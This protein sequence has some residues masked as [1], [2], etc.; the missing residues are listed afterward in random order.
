MVAIASP[1]PASGAYVPAPDAY[2]EAFAARG[3]PRPHYAGVLDALA[4]VDLDALTTA[5]EVDLGRRGVRFGGSGGVAAFHVDPV[6]RVLEAGEWRAL[7]TGL[8]QRTRALNAFVTDVYGPREIV[9]AGV[10]PT[11]V[12]DTAAHLEPLAAELP[13]SPVPPVLVAGLDVV[14]D[15]A[16]AFLVLEDNT[17]TPSGLAFA[18]AARAVVT[19][20]LAPP[21]LDEAASPK[22]AIEGLAHALRAAAPDGEE[23]APVLLSEGPADP[24][25]FEHRTLAEALGVP[26]V[27]LADL[28][29][30][31]DRV[32]TRADAGQHRRRVNVVYRR[33]GESR[34]TRPDGRLT[35]LAAVLL[36]PLRAGRVTCVNAFGAG[37]ADDKLVHGYVED[38]VRFYLDE[39]PVLASVR[40]HGL[41]D[42]GGRA[43]ALDR[44]GELVIKPRGGYGGHGVVVCAHAS[45]GDRRRAAA[46]VRNS[47]AQWVAQ[48]TVVLSCH[49]TVVDG[50][51]V[52]RHVDLRPFTISL[53]GGRVVVA[54]GL[55]RV[56]LT[57]G[58]LVVNSSQHGGAK[59]T[60]ALA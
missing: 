49:P 54:S 42:P 35:A 43:R 44:L 30:R 31:G 53:S 13:P 3:A 15:P 10:V 48:E 18:T 37:V 33:T 1:S 36:G 26:L 14:R 12:I 41:T 4:A 22:A 47:P 59:D 46:L 21:G 38:M 51:L 32:W 55:T 20:R 40:T 24:A 9:A 11:H 16:G 57:P 27:T 8:A 45:D 58:A 23:P 19:S 52:P 50:R 2:D 29:T 34:L 7:A 39:E 56:A 17:R 5:V 28:E 60:W 25:F 6:P